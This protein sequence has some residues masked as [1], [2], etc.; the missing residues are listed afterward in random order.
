GRH[1][2]GVRPGRGRRRLKGT[3]MNRQ[4]FPSAKLPSIRGYR[5]I[6]KIGQGGMGVVYE[7]EEIALKRQVALKVIVTGHHAED[8]ELDRFRKEAQAVALLKHTNVI[9]VHKVW[10]DGDIPYLALEFVD[11]GSLATSAL[12]LLK[13]RI[14]IFGRIGDAAWHKEVCHAEVVYRAADEART[15]RASERCQE[16]EGNGAESPTCTDSAQGRCRRA[17]L[18][19]RA[20]CRGLRVP[21][22]NCGETSPTIRRA[23]I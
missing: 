22:E 13:S 9:Q 6:R 17:P 21:D 11:G 15:S 5:I 1:T 16:A 7:A 10:D 14:G 8:A 12:S 2:S 19:R 3:S 4:G 20:H 18:D 23:G